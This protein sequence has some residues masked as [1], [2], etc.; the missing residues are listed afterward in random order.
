MIAL[1]VL[2]PCSGEPAPVA[3]PAP[4]PAHEAHGAADKVA[5]PA[6]AEA[7]AGAAVAF[8]SPADGA[9]VTSPVHLVFQTTGM[10]VK[11]AGQLIANSGHHHVIVDGQPTPEG[12]AV[13][14]DDTH[15]HFGDGR[16]ETDLVLAPG[17][18]TLTLQF[19]DGLHRSYGPGLSTAITVTVTE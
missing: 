7:P 6:F 14:A 18:H 1:M 11:P 9:S 5:V 12:A 16:T 4:P 13:P 15:I 2:L 3:S 19:A 10:E 8:G 17:E